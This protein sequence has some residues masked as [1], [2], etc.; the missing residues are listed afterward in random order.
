MPTGRPSPHKARE[1]HRCLLI[2]ARALARNE[3]TAADL[4]QDAFI[5][6]FGG[7][8]GAFGVGFSTS[9][10]SPCN[11]QEGN[12]RPARVLMQG[13]QP[14]LRS[15]LLFGSTLDVRRWMFDVRLSRNRGRSPSPRTQLSSNPK[16]K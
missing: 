9:Y 7:H 4:V 2:Y 5:A 15:I 14:P 6:A 8:A 13:L 12:G 3:A 1:H 10:L 11:L 16:F